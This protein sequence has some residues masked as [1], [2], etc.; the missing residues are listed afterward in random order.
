MGKRCHLDI[1]GSSSPSNQAII[2]RQ[3]NEV[4]EIAL[5]IFAIHTSY[6]T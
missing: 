1:T 3:V 5:R 2:V 4:R 6:D